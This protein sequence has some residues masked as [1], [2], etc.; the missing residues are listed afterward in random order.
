MSDIEVFVQ[1]VGLQQMRLIRVP[2]HGTVG[3]LVEAARQHGLQIAENEVAIVLLEDSEESLTLDATLAEAGLTHRGRVQ[4]HRCRRVETA[5]H[6]NGHTEARSFPVGQTLRRVK[7]WAAGQFGMSEGDAA[8][9]ALQVCGSPDRPA[10]D[11]HLGAL[12]S[13]PNCAMCFD[14]VPKQR[15]EGAR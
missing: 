4:I 15:I 9:H 10:E 6:F 3:D 8:E 11:T 13:G 1:G 7:A 14:L 2:D 12:V 5:I